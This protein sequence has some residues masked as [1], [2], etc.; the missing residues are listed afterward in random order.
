[1]RLASFLKVGPTGPHVGLVQARFGPRSDLGRTL[2]GLKVLTFV[3]FVMFP[4]R[5]SKDRVS[6]VQLHSTQRPAA[7][8]SRRKAILHAAETLFSQSCL[9]SV[10]SL[11]SASVLSCLL[12]L[13]PGKA[14]LHAAET[15]FSQSCLVSVVSL[16]KRSFMPQTGSSLSPGNAILH[17]A[18]TLFSQ[19]CLVSCLCF[20][21]VCLLSLLQSC[22]VS[23]L[24]FS[25]SC[26][27]S[28]SASVLSC[29]LSLSP[30]KA[31]LHAAESLFSQDF[32]GRKGHPRVL[33]VLVD[34]WPSDDLDQ[35][36]VLARESG[37]NVFMVSVAKPSADELPMVRTR[38]SH[39]S[40]AQISFYCD[41]GASS[42]WD[43]TRRRTE[44][45]PK[46]TSQR[47]GERGQVPPSPLDVDKSFS[48]PLDVEKLN[49]FFPSSRDVEENVDKFLSSL[50]DVKDN[51]YKSFPSP[52]DVD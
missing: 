15:L 12:S 36:S 48:S 50:C 24:C 42:Q 47:A 8:H 35:A 49:Q 29:L 45:M 40:Q 33:L 13:S 10:V 27:V 39:G 38:T 44:Q 51:V 16:V 1:M 43:A 5:S 20:S 41:F 14:I 4:Q 19:S 23:C 37:I 28:F 9:V 31:I 52:L 22:L 30:G 6:S 17:A 7:G 21:P 25:P 18:E 46:S 2:F 34:G 26:L 11:V 32:G 3:V